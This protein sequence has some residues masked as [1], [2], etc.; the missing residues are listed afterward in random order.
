MGLG[1][2]EWAREWGN[3]RMDKIC[4]ICS[5]LFQILNL[6]NATKG[7]GWRVSKFLFLLIFIISS[8]RCSICSMKNEVYKWFDDFLCAGWRIAVQTSPTWFLPPSPCPTSKNVEH[9]NRFTLFL[10]KTMTYRFWTWNKTWN[11]CGTTWNRPSFY[12]VIKRCDDSRVRFTWR[13]SLI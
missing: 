3:R 4:S 6:Y 9:W 7:G 12:D 10:C 13:W 1:G 5:K 11:K 2:M 8:S